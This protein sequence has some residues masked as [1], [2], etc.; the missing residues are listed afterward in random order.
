MIHNMK[1]AIRYSFLI[2]LIAAPATAQ[3]VADGIEAFGRA[4]YAKALKILREPAE[5]GNSEAQLYLGYMYDYGYGVPEDKI[6][7]VKWY[8][9]AAVQGNAVS[10]NNLGLLYS[11]GVGLAQDL[12]M[13]ADWFRMAAVQG[14]AMGQNNLGLSYLRGSGVSKNE[15]RAVKWFLQS[16]QQG[17]APAQNNL[18]FVYQHGKGVEINYKTALTW[19]RKSA[20]QGNTLGLNNLG[21]MYQRGLGTAKDLK[22]AVKWF[23][24]GAEKGNA[25]SQNS[26][27]VMYAEGKGVRK[28]EREAARWYQKGTLYDFGKGVP[29]DKNNAETWY[30]RAAAQG[31]VRAQINLGYIYEYGGKNVPKDVDKAFKWFKQAADKG[32]ASAQFRLGYFYNS[33]IS[34]SKDQNLAFEWYLK[35]AELGN[36]FAQGS[37]ASLYEFGI[38]G[39]QINVE[40]ALKWYRKAADQG[41]TISQSSLGRMYENGIGVPE[42]D[43]KA[44]MWYRKAAINGYAPAQNKLAKKLEF[45]EGISENLQ[46]ALKWYKR[47]AAKGNAEALTSVA[48]LEKK[49]PVSATRLE[50]NKIIPEAKL[51][52]FPQSTG[53]PSGPIFIPKTEERLAL[54]IGNSSYEIGALNNPI[55]DAHLIS[56]TLQ[57]FNFKIDLVTNVD[58]R[59]FLRALYRFRDRLDEAGPNATALF[60]YSGHG[61]QYD[62]TNYL[63]PVDI[64]NQNFRKRDYETETISANRVLA[65]MARVENGVKIVLLDACRNNPFKSFI[66]SGTKGLGLAR[67]DAPTGTIIGYATKAGGVAVDG[68]GINSPYTQGLVKY[69]NTPDLKVEEVLKATRVWVSQNTNGKQV[70]WDESSLMGDFYFSRVGT[71]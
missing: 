26:L 31:N 36:H 68:E 34:V 52:N 35:S 1:S 6:E 3:T 15:G 63:I 10:Q 69:I 70:P 46:E 44:V 18:G 17:F 33:G 57:K 13:S 67:M 7:A 8:S 47:A 45:G 49:L 41:N 61:V 24:K 38:N 53:K 21:L 50:N 22:K 37:L 59:D 12:E 2:F 71:K 25:N 51:E 56:Q 32:N 4:D 55:R 48:R 42:D 29:D 30:R 40:K 11:K 66:R 62:G 60:Y 20:A 65:A 23:R 16:A 5:I 9:Q 19:Y 28:D 39:K 43:K 58:R 64:K 27:G 14:N 54:V